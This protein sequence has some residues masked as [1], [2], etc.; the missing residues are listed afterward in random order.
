MRFHE[1]NQ[2]DEAMP[3]WA[4]A[5]G[6]AAALGA[7]AFGLS[8]K[9]QD[10]G[11]TKDPEM[12][13]VQDE[14]KI[15]ADPSVVQEMLSLLKTPRGIALVKEARAA[16][17]KGREL[18]QFLA[19]CAHESLNFEVLREL[20][21]QNYFKRYDIK[22]APERAKRLGNLRPGDGFKY[23]GRGFIQL[24]GRENYRRAGRALGLPLEEQP[25][26]VEKPE[27]AAKVAIW[28]WQH[29]VQ[30]KVDDYSDTRSATKPINS[31]LKALD[32]RHEKYEAIAH[33]LG[34]LNWPSLK[35]S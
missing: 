34:V 4:K 12:V 22:Y 7:A 26:L 32:D 13:Y 14:P 33:I 17:M 10:A 29:R 24:T 9:G 30:P 20:G 8:Q 11:Q 27:V 2:L 3:K 18:S 23:I 5:A 21:D 19:Q 16:G 28:F 6:G 31:G 1:F 25:E 35:N 15:V